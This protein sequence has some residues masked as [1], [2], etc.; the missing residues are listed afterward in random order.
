MELAKAALS[1]LIPKLGSLLSAEYNLQKGVRGEIRF[2][3]C[4]MKSMQAALEDLS[5]LPADQISHTNKLWMRDLRELSYDIEDSVDAFM[6]RVDS[7]KPH[8]LTGFRRFIDKIGIIGEV[9]L[10]RKAKIRHRIAMDIEDIKTRVKDVSERRERYRP[11]VTMLPERKLNIDPR[12]IGMFEEANRLVGIDGPAEKLTNMLTQG[13][14]IQKQKLMVASIVGVGGLGKTTLANKVYKKLGGQLFQCQ[15]F[16][17][18]S[19]KPDMKNILCSILRQISR[20]KCKDG[21][22]N[23]PVEVVIQNIR[24]CLSDKR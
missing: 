1:S 6:V 7:P 8:S 16:V 22:E 11:D 21:G 15:A 4:E 5:E 19:L 3:E 9:N 24:D 12:V 2:L 14:S 17:S 20:G 13:D 10:V 18:V 23:D